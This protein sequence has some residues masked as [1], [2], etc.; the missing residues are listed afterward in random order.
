MA[1]TKHAAFR[2]APEL[3]AKLDREVKRV[4]RETGL[5]ISRSDIIRRLIIEGCGGKQRRAK[6]SGSKK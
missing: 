5:E 1:A 6:V 4:S 3:I 2:L